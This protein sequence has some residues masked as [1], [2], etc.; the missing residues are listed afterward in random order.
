[1]KGKKNT[2]GETQRAK[3]V[4]QSVPESSQQLHFSIKRN[5]ASEN[6]GITSAYYKVTLYKDK[7][8][9]WTLL[10]VFNNLR[11]NWRCQ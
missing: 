7:K 11:G 9:K 10:K 2:K 1:V 6:M 5:L 8:I 4:R 3:W